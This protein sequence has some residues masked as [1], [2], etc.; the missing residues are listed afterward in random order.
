MGDEPTHT[1]LL[2][3][4]GGVLTTDIWSSFSAFC[5]QRGLDPE[6]A[7]RLFR[8]NP[9]ALAELRRLET[10]EVDPAEFERRFAT[11]M[12]TEPEGLVDGLFA[13]LAPQQEMVAAVNRARQAGVPT[14]LVSNSWVMDHYTDEIRALFDAVVISG[15]VG[16]HKP[17]PEI[18]RLAAERIDAAPEQCVFVDDLRENCEGAE[19]VGMTAVLHRKPTA[20]LARLEELLGVELA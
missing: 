2:V 11:L 4:F 5:E 19:A 9:A 7:K 20:T 1:A 8:E 18:F 3:D 10:G 12:G 14:G 17:Q 15:E 13:G 16:L 6:A